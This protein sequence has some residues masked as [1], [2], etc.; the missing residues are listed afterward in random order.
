MHI[1]QAGLA[2][3]A[4]PTHYPR[5]HLRPGD[6]SSSAL[7]RH[8][9]YW[10]HT[11]ACCCLFFLAARAAIAEPIRIIL[12]VDARNVT[13]GIQHV[14]LQLPVHSGPLVLA[15]P[16]WIP[17]E[18]KPSGPITQLVNLSFSAGSTP[19]AWRR[20]PMDAYLF[21]IEVPARAPVIDVRFDYYSPP[22]KFGSGFGESPDV[23]PHLLILAFNQFVLYP[24]QASSAEVAVETHVRLPPRWISDCALKPLTST[25]AEVVLPTVSLAT[26]IDSPLL[27]GQHF[28]SIPLSDGP[29]STRISVVADAPVDLEVS[30]SLIK[31]LRGVVSESTAVFG[32]GHYRDYVWLVALSDRLDQDGL[33][34][35]ESSDVRETE[36]L[37]TEPEEAINW[38]LFPH[39]YVH[40]WNGKYRRPEGMVTANYQQPITTDLLWMYE[41]LTRYYGDF[42]LTARSGLASGAQS[43]EYLAYVAALMDRDRPGRSWR[44]LA[45][46]ATAVPAY[47]NA[48]TEWSTVRRAADYYG[49]MLLVWLEADMRIRQ[50]TGGVQSLD[51]FSRRFFG[52]PAPGLALKSYSRGDVLNAL[53]DVVP[54][55]WNGFFS[56]RLE[57]L[58][59]NAPLNGIHDSGWTLTYDDVPNDFVAA[60]EKI[61]TTNDLSLSLG[62]WTRPDGTVLDVVA[63]SPGFAAGLAPSMKLL[64]IDGHRW[65]STAAR[66][67]VIHAE[68]V[69][70]PLELFVAEEDLVRVVEVHYHGGLRFP[71]LIRVESQPD[72]LSKILAARVGSAR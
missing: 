41:G 66:D 55:D 13:Q 70:Q 17:G 65:T 15:Y 71:H 24:A 72:T 25:D 7:A 63:G 21:R 37:L 49:E 6:P 5:L 59:S 14:H 68:N 19:L 52:G 69:A 61:S 3:R 36:R 67:A 23:T 9:P 62:I 30:E 10:Q 54:V 43:R 4:R 53:R 22:Q 18:H 26:L 27:A 28:R 12:E 31:G 40:A 48:P 50:L 58:N 11:A 46:T 8:G 51:D 45:D 42:V 34:H 44:S 38:R 56:S 64:A 32:R 60:L 39:E 33:E 57:D 1:P 20:E 2:S 47:A 16:K 29:Q 35:Y